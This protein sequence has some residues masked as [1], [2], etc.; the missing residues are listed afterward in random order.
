MFV[1]ISASKSSTN[2]FVSSVPFRL[3][4][5]HTNF[6][7]LALIRHTTP[8]EPPLSNATKL[9]MNSPVRTSHSFTVPSSDEVI[10]NRLLNCRQVTADWCLKGPT[11]TNKSYSNLFKP[12]N[13]SSTE[14]SNRDFIFFST[15]Y[16]KTVNNQDKTWT[17]RLV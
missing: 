17:N 10:T 4:T 11:K 7:S 13:Y 6:V 8:P 2:N 9:R 12:R 1:L 3:P 15:F 14:R 16:Y 5:A